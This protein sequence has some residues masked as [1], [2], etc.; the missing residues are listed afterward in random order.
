LFYGEAVR[1]EDR[2]EQSER[3]AVPPLGG[4]YQRLW[5]ATAISSLGN[6]V[7][8]AA[9]PLLAHSLTTSAPAIS[10]VTAAT[11]LPGLLVALHAGAMVDRLDRR[12]VMVTMDVARLAILVAFSFLIIGTHTPLVAVYLT[13]FALGAADVTFEGAARSVVPAVVPAERLDAANGRLNAAIDTM[14]ELLGP[15]TGVALF[16]IAVAAPFLFDAGTFAVSAVLLATIAGTFRAAPRPEIAGIV[17]GGDGGDGGNGGGAT[18]EPSFRREIG[19]G[20]RFVRSSRLLTT[21]SIGTAMLAFFSA[22]NMSVF[23]VYTLDPNGLDLPHAGY[24]YLLMTIAIGGVL[25]S[26]ILEPLTR[27]FD[28]IAVLTVAVTLNG[29]G[30]LVFALAHNLIVITAATLLWGGAIS[31]G[32]II[33]IGLRQSLTPDHLLGRVM[34]VF[35]VLVGLGGV[36]GALLGGVLVDISLRLPYLSAGIAQI[37]LAP[38]FGAA[39]ARGRAE[40]KAGSAPPS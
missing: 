29:V 31:V 12:R 8:F 18:P 27:R 3:G 15:P 22:A 30:Y 19:E 6:G 2:Q 5:T 11:A 36:V 28:Q 24:G 33:S 25:G 10:A 4:G 40:M 37:A 7:L 13:A 39:L 32:M 14:N 34:S 20:L 23:V 9:M 17:D 21:L 35:R 16:A 1:R 26:L 38:L